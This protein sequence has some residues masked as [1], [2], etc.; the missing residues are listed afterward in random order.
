[1]LSVSQTILKNLL[2][3]DDYVRKVKPF[4]ND[5]YFEDPN[6]KL[7]FS[8]LKEYI[9]KY[10]GLPSK[11]ALIID[12]SNNTN[13]S[14]EQIDKAGELIVNLIEDDSKTPKDW[15]IDRTEQWCQEQALYNAIMESIHIIDEKKQ[16]K[17]KT[18]TGSI[19]SILSQALSVCFDPNVGHDYLENSADAYK[20]YHEPQSRIS[21]GTESQTKVFHLSLFQF[22]LAELTLVKL[23]AC[24][25]LLVTF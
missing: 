17:G 11:E 19:P 6:E 22:Y 16:G 3:D 12:I 1:M 20:M 13:L 21:W 4:I 15:L 14:D 23:C 9:E 5:A 10:N 25:I 18:D 7:V 24:A 8:N 2:Q